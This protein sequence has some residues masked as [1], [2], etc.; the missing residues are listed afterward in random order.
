MDS[1]KVSNLFSSLPFVMTCN[2]TVKPLE[3]TV[4]N[5]SYTEIAEIPFFYRVDHL[6]V[7]FTLLSPDTLRGTLGVRP[8]QILLYRE[9]CFSLQFKKV[10]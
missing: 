1:N 2:F 8:R 6:I 4:K 7:H 10:F 3:W 9:N 5:L